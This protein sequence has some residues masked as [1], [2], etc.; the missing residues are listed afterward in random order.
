MVRFIM[1]ADPDT[2]F[3]NCYPDKNPDDLREGSLNMRLMKLNM[4]RMSD[5]KDAKNSDGRPCA[6]AAKF[7]YT[8]L[9]RATQLYYYN[10]IHL[11]A[12]SNAVLK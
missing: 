2:S 7:E 3:T 11:L 1:T 5:A 6:R 10:Y 4:L 9:L 8:D 12:S